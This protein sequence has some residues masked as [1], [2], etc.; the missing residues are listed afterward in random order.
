MMCVRIHTSV[1]YQCNGT[2]MIYH[3]HSVQM[4]HATLYCVQITKEEEFLQDKWPPATVTVSKK[5][6]MCCT[7]KKKKSSNIVAVK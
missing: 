3:V 5:C 4:N 6:L 7:K 2:W 1:Y